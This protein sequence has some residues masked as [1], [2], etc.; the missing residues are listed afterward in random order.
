M[1]P[2]SGGLCMAAWPSTSAPKAPCQCIEL[3]FSFAVEWVGTC[4]A[5][6][7]NIAW[8]GLTYFIAK[9]HSWLMSA[10]LVLCGSTEK[11]PPTPKYHLQI[12]TMRE[13]NDCRETTILPWSFCIDFL[14]PLQVDNQSWNKK[15]AG[16]EH[17]SDFVETRDIYNYILLTF[18]IYI[19][20]YTFCILKWMDLRHS[21]FVLDC[22]ILSV[23][24]PKTLPTQPIRLI[25]EW[26]NFNMF[27]IARTLVVSV[28]FSSSLLDISS[29]R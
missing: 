9:D 11:A 22:Q 17:Q 28:K 4:W 3:R 23:W 7:T 2:P 24:G 14:C 29:W 13:H 19:Y 18:A 1:W 12:M 6:L 10:K 15:C 26:N 5:G 27:R 25:R 20:I 21:L 8:E 16:L